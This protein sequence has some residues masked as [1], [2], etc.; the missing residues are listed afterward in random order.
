MTKSALIIVDVQN[1]FCKGGSLAVPDANEIIPIINMIREQ[2][3]F[4]MIVLTQDFHPKNH[5][6]FASNHKGK[7]VFDIIG[8]NGLKQVLWPDHCVQNTLGAGF[9]PDLKIER[10]DIIIQKGMDPDVDSYSGFYDNNHINDT[11]LAK[12]LHDNE[13][14]E[15]LIAG[16]ATDYCVKFTALDAVDEG[17][18]TYIIVDAIRGVD[19]NMG[20]VR[21]ALIDMENR[22]VKFIY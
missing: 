5:K 9:H 17:F 19:A 11:G 10:S 4:D 6:S 7:K 2:K 18:K 1:D 15:V 8:L 12:L 14:E 21:N 3:N 20:D 13:I 16:L 22:G